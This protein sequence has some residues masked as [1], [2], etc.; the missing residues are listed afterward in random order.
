MIDS[1][2]AASVLC[3]LFAAALSFL[4]AS[5]PQSPLV[6][7]DYRDLICLGSLII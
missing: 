4:L 5:L 1:I 6:L 2:L 7:R 3:F